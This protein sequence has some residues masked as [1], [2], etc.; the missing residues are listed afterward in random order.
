MTNCMQW[1]GKVNGDGYGQFG[2]RLPDGR[3]T[4]VKA[5]RRAWEA[6]FGPIPT[7]LTIDHD[8]NN[9]G[10]INP[11][12]M[13]VVTLAENI[14]RRDLRNPGYSRGTPESLA[15]RGRMGTHNRWHRD[16]GLTVA[17]CP[18]CGGPNHDEL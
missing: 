16:R 7:G 6:F 8:C 11:D 18:H 1:E 3:W 2:E 12:H 10:C 17:G 14:R 15:A 13:E 4:T 9:H 5:H